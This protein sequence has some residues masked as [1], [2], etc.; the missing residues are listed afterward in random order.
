MRIACPVCG[1][2]GT[3]TVARDGGVWIQVKVIHRKGEACAAT[4][5]IC[6]LPNAPGGKWG[7]AI[8]PTTLAGGDQYLT[9]FIEQ[10]APPHAIYA[11]LFGGFAAVLSAKPPAYIEIYNDINP[12]VYNLMYCI[13]RRRCLSALIARIRGATLSRVVWRSIIDSIHDIKPKADPD[14][15]A[16]FAFLYAVFNSH[17]GMIYAHPSF[18]LPTDG[19]A[20]SRPVTWHINMP[21][22]LEQLHRRIRRVVFFNRHWRALDRW[23]ECKN[24]WIYLDPPHHTVGDYDNYRFYAARWTREDFEDVL[25]VMSRARAKVLLKYTDR[26]GEVAEAA[27]RMGLHYITVKYRTAMKAQK[28]ATEWYS[29]DTIYTF[30]ANYELPRSVRPAGYVTKIIEVR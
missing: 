23:F 16:A 1:R 27:R 15:D 11:E 3:I 20:Q 18:R 10:L 14:P 4:R 29:V 13:A 8:R 5:Y 17:N 26:S 7:R 28:L 19:H 2:P 6:D 9:S 24:A 25:R 12:N 30:V 21:E 22:R